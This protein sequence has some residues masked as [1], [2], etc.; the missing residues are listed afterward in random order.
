MSKSILNSVGTMNN[1]SVYNHSRLD[2][3]RMLE[4]DSDKLFYTK[5]FLKRAEYHTQHVQNA[6][7]FFPHI[8]CIAYFA[9]L[10]D[11]TADDVVSSTSANAAYAYEGPL[12]L[13]GMT[14]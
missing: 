4:Y 8:H 10:Y 12:S 14:T 2:G 6:L 7:H 11:S 1:G 13:E 5:N 3:K 9:L